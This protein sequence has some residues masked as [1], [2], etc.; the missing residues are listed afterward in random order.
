MRVLISGATGLIGSALSA[1]LR[2][3]AHEVIVLTRREAK[4]GDPSIQWNPADRILDRARL[5]GFDA[6]IHLAGENI[7]KR[8]TEDARR[9]IRESRVEGTRFLCETL[10]GLEQPP[11]V[12]IGASAIGY[13]GNRG[14]EIL[15]ESS[16]AGAGFLADLCREWEAAAD[17]VRRRGLR[18]VHARLGMVLSPR[19]GALGAMLIPFKLGLGGVI[20]SG[21]QYMSWIAIDD[22]VGALGHILRAES[23]EGPV[24]VTAPYPAT[25]RDFTKT[26][27]KVLNRPTLFPL[28]AFAARAVFGPMA[29]EM[30][31]GGARVIPQKL[32]DSGYV[33]QTPALED[34]LR[35]VLGK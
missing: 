11:C 4:P 19:G 7:A 8:W 12:F 28:P 22:A 32:L 5:E 30:L 20:G 33:F 24:N 15:T 3:E 14:D 34:A 31:L 29:E 23:I 9:R 35:H 21:K 27:G 10:A 25:N 13:Y 18:V 1:F 26:V 6:V 16:A 17:P 2:N